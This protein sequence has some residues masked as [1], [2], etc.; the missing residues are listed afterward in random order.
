VSGY[1][2]NAG[3]GFLT[4]SSAVPFLAGTT[5]QTLT[6]EPAEKF[7]FVANAGANSV[8]V[9]NVNT[10]TGILTPAPVISFSVGIQPQQATVVTVGPPTVQFVYL[11]NAGSS[12][13]S[14][15]FLNTTTGFL[16]P[17]PGSPFA[18]GAAPQSVVQD[19]VGNFVYV[20]NE[21]AAS[22]SAFGVDQTTGA[23]L[24]TVAGAPFT[25]GTTPQPVTLHPTKLFA[26]V[27]NA[28]SSNLS[29]YSV[30]A[31]TGVL[32]IITNPGP[33]VTNFFGAG[34]SPQQVTIDPTGK[35]ALVA[36]S[37]SDDVSVY[38]IDQTT[39]ELAEVAGSP[40]LAGDLP[41]RATVDPTGKFVFVPNTVSNNVSVYRLNSTTGFLTPVTGS[42]FPAGTGPQFVTTAGTF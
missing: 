22:I 32:S 38:A 36:N 41:R 35:F 39:G 25:A 1:L 4:P 27:A 34:T 19:S 24:A 12:N 8:S 14:G 10:T 15:F 9:Y 40:F 6:L 30:I 26:Y 33:P 23:L 21:G 31:G 28:G 3:T 17:A 11:A 7:A 20:S 29:A 2:L 13:V 18:V 16:T 5:P 42:P 37:G